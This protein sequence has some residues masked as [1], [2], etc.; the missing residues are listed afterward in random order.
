MCCAA[1]CG[2]SKPVKAP[3][4]PALTH[5]QQTKQLSSKINPR[6]LEMNFLQRAILLYF[7]NFAIEV[8]D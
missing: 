6:K 5:P 4:T 1:D 7:E 8:P 2:T 3:E